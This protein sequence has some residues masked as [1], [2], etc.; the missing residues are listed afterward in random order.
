MQLTALGNLRLQTICHKPL[1]IMDTSNFPFQH[2]MEQRHS[3]KPTKTE[4]NF[5][6]ILQEPILLLNKKMHD[7]RHL[8][9]VMFLMSAF[10]ASGEW[11]WDYITDPIGAQ[12][13]I[14][15]RLIFLVLLIY[16]FIFKQI[17]NRR[18]IEF[19]GVT[20][21]LVAIIIFVEILNRL[22][23][24]ITQGLGIFIYL[25]FLPVVMFQCFSLRVNLISTFLY[26]AT[27]QVMYLFGLIPNFPAAQ[28]AAMVWPA[29]IVLM[30]THYIFAQNYRRRYHL[31]QALELASNTD[32]M[33][34]VSNRRHFIPI[35]HNEIIRGNRFNH[36]V[37]LMVLDI[38][39]FKA[40]NDAHGHP[41]GDLVICTLADICKK[42]ARQLDVIARLGGEEFAILV[43][44]APLK[45]ALIA[46]ERIRAAVAN[47]RLT[48]FDGFEFSFTVSI[49]V[50]EQP[51][52][53]Y[54]EE[55]LINLAD[56][57][58]YQAKDAGRNCVM[59]STPTG[60]K[61]LATY[62]N[63]VEQV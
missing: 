30:I 53:D 29:A 11:I 50:A 5:F 35:L 34:G 49:G 9:A 23:N 8:A 63:E 28:Y 43:I 6:S 38:D 41:T 32:S 10:L 24:G 17:R 52:D 62:M 44:N 7:H 13:T 55:H 1:W 4:F 16:P 37:S 40:I 51:K 12:N 15:L 20:S 18:M 25:L 58:L 19:I 22:H 61:P 27:P 45:N 2:L 26:A 14:E 59:A 42:T 36:A 46:A 47:T 54:S 56:A 60:I 21:G 3:M 39:H 31:E 33:T 48:S 57:A